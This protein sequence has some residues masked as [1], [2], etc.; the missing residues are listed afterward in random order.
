MASIGNS[1]KRD[2]LRIGGRPLL[3]VPILMTFVFLVAFYRNQDAL[4]DNPNNYFGDKFVS[5]NELK[6]SNFTD[7]YVV[8]AVVV[9]GK[10]T[11]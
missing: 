7:Q 1:G 11:N 5:P 4:D 6:S 8:I 3:A 10:D 2:G 9:K